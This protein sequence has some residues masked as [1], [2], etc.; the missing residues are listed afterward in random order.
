MINKFLTII[1]LSTT[2][3][4]CFAALNDEVIVE[5][6]GQ[7]SVETVSTH[8]MW[9]KPSCVAYT[10]GS[11]EESFLEVVAYYDVESDSFLNPFVSVVSPFDVSFFEVTVKT[12]RNRETFSLLPAFVEGSELV[13][14]RSLIEDTQNFVSALKRR[15]S[16]TAQYLDTEGVAKQVSFSLSG[17][18][19][20]INAQFDECKL[21]FTDLSDLLNEEITPELP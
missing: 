15:N 8:D 17:S 13:G 6:S 7:W 20:A 9:N 19:A 11:D 2:S 16:V 12:D 4:L 1:L 14:A 10:K 21:S 5:K 3:S 18:S